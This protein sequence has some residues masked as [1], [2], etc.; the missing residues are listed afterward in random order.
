MVADVCDCLIGLLALFGRL[1]APT[2]LKDIQGN[3]AN[4]P[5]EEPMPEEPVPT[6]P[7]PENPMPTKPVLEK[8]LPA[9]PEQQTPCTPVAYEID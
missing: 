7:V 2:V 8:P 9:I 4:P 6:N 1:I 3:P 5:P